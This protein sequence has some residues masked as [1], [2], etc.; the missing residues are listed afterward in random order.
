M[1]SLNATKQTL[2]Q[3]E[4]LAHKL[5]NYTMVN[6][7]SLREQMQHTDENY[8]YSMP[9]WLLILITVLGTLMIVAGIT[10]FLYCKYIKSF[11]DFNYILA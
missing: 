2:E 9:T 8:L 6:Y 7:Y 3:L 10:I 1:Q 4:Q 5:L 11:Q